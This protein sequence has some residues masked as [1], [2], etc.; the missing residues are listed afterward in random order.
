MSLGSGG[1]THSIR[2]NLGFMDEKRWKEFSTR[3][4]EL[5]DKFNLH[6]RKASEQD[7]SIRQIA[8]LLREEFGFPPNTLTDFDKLVRAAIQSVRRNRKRSSRA[9][10]HTDKFVVY[11][12]FG[13]PMHQSSLPHQQTHH[14]RH[15]PHSASSSGSN[16]NSNSTTNLAAGFGMGM[17]L[18]MGTATSH[19]DSY[20]LSMNSSGAPTPSLFSQPSLQHPVNFSS[21]LLNTNLGP[22]QVLQNNNSASSTGAV[23]AQNDHVSPENTKVVINS[24][25]SSNTT[26]TNNTTP[27]TSLATSPSSTQLPSIKALTSGSMNSVTSLPLSNSS[28]S[29]NKID[30]SPQAK[31]KLL[32]FIQK[33]KSCLMLSNNDSS[34]HEENLHSLGKSVTMASIS[35]ILERF[36]ADI[37]SDSINYLFDKL[38]TSNTLSKIL[39]SLGF[40][41]ADVLILTDIQASNLLS[42]LIGCCVKDFGF[43]G[44]SYTLGEIFHEIILNEYPLVAT[45]V[46]KITPESLFTPM[47]PIPPKE[48]DNEV[49]KDV[50]LKY[51]QRVLELKFSPLSA[52]PPTY[53]EL[54]ENGKVAFGIQG[55]NIRLKSDGREL[56]EED[57]SKLFRDLDRRKVVVELYEVG[58]ENI[59]FTPLL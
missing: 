2:E 27:S 34:I 57:V 56:R 44:V 8:N 37:S 28:G 59:K 53:L 25:L 20:P 17:G 22:P 38:Q 6:Q 39:K 24:L 9:R 41:S 11:D 58:A 32:N 18:N 48:A 40:F 31:Q 19:S 7:D 50:T 45:Q 13:R 12:E 42:K 3:R 51:G 14:Q 26:T 54:V 1:V 36:F 15:G 10:V 55:K 52:A 29:T 46:T 5:I 23:N 16:S 21:T 33:S 35:F 30:I 4:L 49:V 43:D 47:L